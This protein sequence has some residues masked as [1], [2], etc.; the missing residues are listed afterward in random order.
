[1][2][3]PAIL[4]A[5][6]VPSSVQSRPPA[7]ANTPQAITALVNQLLHRAG[8]PH[9]ELARQLG[10]TPSSLTQYKYGYRHNP[11]IGWLLRLCEI[12]GVRVVIEWPDR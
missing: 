4:P 12:V 7:L 1:M 2:T 9:A 10:I 6:N 8:V 5:S 3:P 11:T